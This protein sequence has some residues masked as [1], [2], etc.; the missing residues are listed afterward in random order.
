VDAKIEGMLLPFINSPIGEA[1]MKNVTHLL[2]LVQSLPR[3]IPQGAPK[4]I[5]MTISLIAMIALVLLC[6]S[7]K[8]KKL[9]RDIA[10]MRLA[11][12]KY[13]ER[14]DSYE[15]YI[16]FMFTNIKYLQQAKLKKIQL[17]AKY[18]N[19][20]KEPNLIKNKQQAI[21]EYIQAKKIYAKR[22]SEFDL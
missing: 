1:E 16:L 8:L 6:V 3:Y 17:E 22:F 5:R 12:E 19:G 14:L 11:D 18:R 13:K 21:E 10:T 20:K 4:N 2:I 7:T 15:T 9:E